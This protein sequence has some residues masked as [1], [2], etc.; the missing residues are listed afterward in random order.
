MHTMMMNDKVDVTSDNQ[1]VVADASKSHTLLDKAFLKESHSNSE[2]YDR[3]PPKHRVGDY[4]RRT[5][6]PRYTPYS[7]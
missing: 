5:Y 7:K 2:M 3:V 1:L 6:P 4:E